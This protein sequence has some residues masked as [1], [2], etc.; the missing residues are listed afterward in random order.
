MSESNFL[1]RRYSV[2]GVP[3]GNPG[4]YSFYNTRR[5][6]RPTVISSPCPFCGLAQ[7]GGTPLS[8]VGSGDDYL[9]FQNNN[10]PLLPLQLLLAPCAHREQLRSSDIEVAMA[11]TSG[12]SVPIRPVMGRPDLG[13][14][15]EHPAVYFNPC[16]G[17]G[18][19]IAHLHGNLLDSA[20]LPMPSFGVT[21]PV[22]GNPQWAARG[23]FDG[24]GYCCLLI[25]GDS[26]LDIG[27]GTELIG[28]YLTARGVGFNVLVIPATKPQVVLVPRAKEYSDIGLQRIAG[29]ELMTLYLQ[30]S[31]ETVAQSMTSSRRDQAIAEVTL[32][33][34]EFVKLVEGLRDEFGL[35]LPQLSTT[36]TPATEAR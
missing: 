13:F 6:N 30:P 9:V 10:P 5:A 27:V 1:G 29:L 21:F 36:C 33:Q 32:T 24:P 26:F 2:P 20:M 7:S 18:R 14:R 19:S 28:E 25:Q 35:A 17:S 3:P 16:P 34:A 11:L 4:S 12:A 22:C 15:I 31:N 8:R 23:C